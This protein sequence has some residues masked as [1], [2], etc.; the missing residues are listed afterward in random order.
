MINNKKFL[1]WNQ[2]V[3]LTI[4]EVTI[5]FKRSGVTVAAG[6]DGH[7]HLVY[8]R[9]SHESVHG[10]APTGELETSPAERGSISA[11]CR[12]RGVLGS[13]G[14]HPQVPKFH[15]SYNRLAFPRVEGLEHL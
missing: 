5:N 4:S 8:P 3:N 7:G 12:P 13:V 2:G 9:L 11:L 15:L 6:E 10:L 1:S 14:R